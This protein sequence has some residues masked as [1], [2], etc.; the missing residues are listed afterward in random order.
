MLHLWDISPFVLQA[1]AI[2]VLVIVALIVLLFVWFIVLEYRYGYID[3]D[4]PATY[5][6]TR[7][8]DARHAKYDDRLMRRWD[9]QLARSPSKK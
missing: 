6:Y 1:F 3:G 8:Q 7:K 5:S 4:D 9:K 2:I